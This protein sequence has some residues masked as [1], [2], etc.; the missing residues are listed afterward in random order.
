MTPKCTM[1]TNKKYFWTLNLYHPLI[2]QRHGT[3]SNFKL[4]LSAM[5]NHLLPNHQYSDLGKVY[6]QPSLSPQI[7]FF[8]VEN[9][10]CRVQLHTTVHRST[11]VLYQKIEY[12][13][14]PMTNWQGNETMIC[15]KR[16]ESR[17]WKNGFGFKEDFTVRNR[18]FSSIGF[19]CKS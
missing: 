7:W 9:W 19:Y 12:R 14:R 11:L 1:V 4:R 3:I 13:P 5:L 16:R 6:G 8:L 15:L 17:F 10:N 2:K 18:S